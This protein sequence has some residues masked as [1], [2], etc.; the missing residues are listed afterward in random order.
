MLRPAPGMPLTAI[1]K[2]AAMEDRL[3]SRKL[4]Y[5]VEAIEQGSLNRAA[6]SLRI[7]QPALSKAVRTLELELGISLL[8]RTSAGVRP[9]SYGKALYS[10]AKAVIAE[11]TYARMQIDGLKRNEQRQIVVGTLSTYSGPILALALARLQSDRHGICPVKIVEKPEVELT[12]ELRRGAFDFAL[13]LVRGGND[14][15]G[16]RERALLF[17]ERKLIVRANHPLAKLKTVTAAELARYPW[18]LPSAGTIHRAP[19]EQMFRD[20]KL[21]PPSSMIEGGSLQFHLQLMLASDY[22]VSLSTHSVAL[23][24]KQRQM[25]VLPFALPKLHRTIGIIT[26]EHYEIPP[27]ANNLVRQIERVCRDLAQ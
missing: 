18:V 21:D 8:E 26:R 19:M 4:R 13:G 9:T 15:E 25:A 11:L 17:D 16:L 7:S 5:F 22:I 27:V 20:A 10:H 12:A 23:L 6:T 1:K 2:R 24:L 14:A 3:D